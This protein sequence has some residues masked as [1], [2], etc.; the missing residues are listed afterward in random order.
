MPAKR[1]TGAAALVL[2]FIAQ[3][4]SAVSLSINGIGQALIYP[5]YTVNKSQDT[6]IS[7]MK[8]SPAIT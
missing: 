6:L 7:V 4:V 5:Y 2:L 8:P 1:L 3:S